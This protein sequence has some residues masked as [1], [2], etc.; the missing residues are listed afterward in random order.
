M[1][2]NDPYNTDFLSF[3]AVDKVLSERK[4]LYIRN[5]ARHH[6]S[7]AQSIVVINFPTHEGGRSFSIPRTSVPFNIC[8]HI[9]PDSL[10][11]SESFRKLLN[12]GT[13]EVVPDTTAERELRD[14]AMREAFKA[15]YN[16]ANNTYQARKGETQAGREANASAKAEKQAAQSAG[17]KNIIAA[18]DP[19]LA[20]ALNI[21]GA[22]GIKAD[23][24]LENKRNPRLVA[25]EARVKSGTVA[26]HAVV[27]EISLMLGDLKHEDLVGIASGAF[28]PPEAQKWAR[29][30]I[31]F[32]M[33]AEN[34]AAAEKLAAPGGTL[35]QGGSVGFGPTDQE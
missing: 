24:V 5:Q 31:A 26:S 30:R 1:T 10:R 2:T 21:T 22:D 34:E 14:P 3:S 15:A 9:D 33:Q 28:W 8:D 13:L 20:E 19:K 29:D 18:M 6:A 25:L 17:M 4:A 12:N 23:P 32:Q 7:G 27:G 16:E 35:P 11:S